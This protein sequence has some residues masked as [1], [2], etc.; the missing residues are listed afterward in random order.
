MPFD[1]QNPL[2]PTDSARRTR[3][4]PHIVVYLNPRPDAPPPDGI[5]DRVAPAKP[6][7]DGPDD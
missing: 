6:P 4:V 5:D 3:A 7:G 1:S 2:D